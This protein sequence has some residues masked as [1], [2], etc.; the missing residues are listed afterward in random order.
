MARTNK[1]KDIY[2]KVKTNFTDFTDGIA[3]SKV[4]EPL[5]L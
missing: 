3:R 1:L 5:R 4:L 2:S